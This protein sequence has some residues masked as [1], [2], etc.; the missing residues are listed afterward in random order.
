MFLVFVDHITLFSTLYPDMV[1]EWI[2]FPRHSFL[3]FCYLLHQ[4]ISISKETK[5]SGLKILWNG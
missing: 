2:L 3:M 4:C 5:L 1:P